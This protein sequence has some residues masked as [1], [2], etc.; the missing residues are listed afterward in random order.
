[1]SDAFEP[2]YGEVDEFVFRLSPEP[3]GQVWVWREAQWMPFLMTAGEVHELTGFA[4]LSR[5]EV[6]QRGIPPDLP[7]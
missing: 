7:V 4:L 5:D 1:V 3:D 2:E 6:M